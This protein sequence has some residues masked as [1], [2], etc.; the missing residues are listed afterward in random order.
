MYSLYS[1]ICGPRHRDLVKG[2]SQP[3]RH[4]SATGTTDDMCI[5]VYIYIYIYIYIIHICIYI[6]IYIYT[7]SLSLYIHR[8]QREELARHACRIPNVH[9]IAALVYP[10]TC[11][12]ACAGTFACVS[13][14]ECW[15]SKSVNPLFECMTANIPTAIYQTTCMFTHT[16][17]SRSRAC[18]HE[19]S[20]S[21]QTLLYSQQRI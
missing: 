5:Y 15:P 1:Y 10:D 19:H 20:S 17:M 16:H 7:Y 2:P 14:G 4:H 8:R 18:A 9:G 12:H 11:A 21:K 3:A 6:Y 13:C